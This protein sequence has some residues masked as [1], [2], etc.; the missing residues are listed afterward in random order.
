MDW[1]FSLAIVALLVVIG[2]ILV[3]TG[4]IDIGLA[5]DH[6]T[7]TAGCVRGCCTNERGGTDCVNSTIP[8]KDRTDGRTCFKRFIGGVEGCPNVAGAKNIVAPPDGYRQFESCW[9]HY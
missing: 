2:A 1:L 6:G 3:G 4:V 8:C 7:A 9:I 5:A